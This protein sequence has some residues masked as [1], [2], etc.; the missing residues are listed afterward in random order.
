MLRPKLSSFS[1]LI[2]RQTLDGRLSNSIEKTLY[3]RIEPILQRIKYERTAVVCPVIDSISDSSMQYMGGGYGGI[4]T[5]WW[6]LHYKMDPMPEAEKRRRKNPDI[7]Y[8]RSPT[9]VIFGSYIPFLKVK[10]NNL[11]WRPIRCESR[12]LLRSWWLRPRNGHLG[13]RKP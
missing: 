12:V 11:G 1:I 13:R 9:M 2:A 10:L 8:I 3:F 7:D 5:F 6:S 4:G